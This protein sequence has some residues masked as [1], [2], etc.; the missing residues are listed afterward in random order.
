MNVDILYSIIKVLGLVIFNSMGEYLEVGE[1]HR[2]IQYL[3]K[4][5]HVWVG[6]EIANDVALYTVALPHICT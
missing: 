3:V 5:V 2:D 6:I 4:K 1:V